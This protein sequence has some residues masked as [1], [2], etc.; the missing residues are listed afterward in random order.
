MLKLRLLTALVLAPAAIAA[1]LL[2]PT[3]ALEW[4]FAAMILAGAWEWSRL[5]GLRRVMSR[6]LY[7]TVTAL[8][9]WVV[10]TVW[11]RP[12]LLGA[13]MIATL[14]WWVL[15]FL[16]IMVYPAGPSGRPA[17]TVVG[18]VAGVFVLVPAWLALI[19]LHS[20]PQHGPLWVLFVLALIWIADSG[21]YF[22]GRRWGKRKLSPRVS[23]GKTR[24]GVYG[25][26]ALVL[27]YAVAA[28]WLLHVPESRFVAFVLLCLVLV[29]VSVVGD[30][31]ESLI[32]RQ[33]GFKDSGALLPGHGGVM[34]RIDSLTA[35]APVFLLGLLWLNIPT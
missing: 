3:S 16:W 30:L 7:V 25:A 29:P 9:L 27:V 20:A 26:L 32:K 2:L 5:S 21:A 4:V 14:L 35:T 17:L 6:A 15:A 31:F 19:A 22:F 23:P 28:G 18:L 8:L 11:Q 12:G 1:I 13:I 34:D 10:A 33:S 24:E